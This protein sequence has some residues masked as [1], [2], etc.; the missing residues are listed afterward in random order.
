MDKQE[1]KSSVMSRMR[2]ASD[3]SLSAAQPQGLTFTEIKERVMAF[4]LANE[5]IGGVTAF[6]QGLDKDDSKEGTRH[7]DPVEEFNKENSNT[8]QI[9]ML[10]EHDM[11][12]REA[13]LLQEAQK[14]ETSYNML[15]FGAAIKLANNEPMS[16]ALRELIVNHLVGQ[17]PK[18]P[19]QKAGRRPSDPLVDERKYF[20]VLFAVKHGLRPSRN[21]IYTQPSACDVVEAAALELSKTGYSLFASGYGYDNLKK[22]Y[23]RI[24]KE[25]KAAGG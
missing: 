19:K 20:A 12:L 24:R 13:E 15:L 16:E 14:H 11:T 1:K 3:L 2:R 18:F 6:G 25:R 23:F 8:D 22:I 7:Y 21:E 17:I 4:M 10:V 9:M 5:R